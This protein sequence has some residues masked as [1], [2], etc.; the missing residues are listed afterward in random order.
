MQILICNST[1]NNISSP[2]LRQLWIPLMNTSGKSSS[3]LLL[4]YPHVQLLLNDESHCI[5]KIKLKFN[6]FQ[7]CIHLAIFGFLYS[8][9]KWHQFSPWSDFR[10]L[11]LSESLHLNL[12]LDQLSAL[13]L[14]IELPLLW[15]LCP[16]SIPDFKTLI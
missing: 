7:D 9:S 3:S 10:L 16:L 4:I 12:F 5:L 13:Y 6:I 8:F 11:I 14:F 1:I 15:H 2:L